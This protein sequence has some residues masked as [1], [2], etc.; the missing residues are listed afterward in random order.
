MIRMA[1][2]VERRFA[3]RVVWVCLLGWPLAAQTSSGQKPAELARGVVIPRVTCVA[4]AQQSYALYLPSN[5]T[6]EH[7][8][9]IIYAFDP[10]AR[11]GLPVELLKEIA[12]RRGY[13]V[14]GS[15]NSR[16]GPLKVSLDAAE[17]V[18]RDTYARLSIDAR[19]VYMTGF[20]GGAR[21]AADI[22]LNCHDCAAGVIAHGAGFE[23]GA[24]KPAEIHFRYFAA[25]GET[26]FNYPELVE[27]EKQLDAWGVSNRVRRYPAGHQWAS[28]E[29]WE[30]AIEWMELQAMKDGR[31]SKNELWISEG[32]ARGLERARK[33][34]QAGDFYAAYEEYR[35]LALD[36][37][38]L[39][40]TAALEQKAGELKKNAAVREG[41][42]REQKEIGQQQQLTSDFLGALGTLQ[43]GA[44]DKTAAIEALS[45]KAADFGS[46]LK[47]AKDL[48]ENRV[49]L[50]A[51]GQV[52]ASAVETGRELFQMKDYPPAEACFKAASQI[53][54][55]AP[56]PYFQLAR[57]YAQ[58][59][60]KKNVA[61][62]LEKA[63]ENGLRVEAL[64]NA[65]ELAAMKDDPEIQRLVEKYSQTR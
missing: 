54:P 28:A 63:F 48:S 61:G 53:S 2:H 12:E 64:E 24:R 43:K 44:L 32:R 5:Y 36:Y 13:I 1:I 3:L 30:E 39:A 10:G 7:A 15:N 16:N 8:W 49:L 50:R 47:R 56:G 34:E 65:P 42:K 35:R 29:I 62:M 20:S 11:G 9:P 41:Q 45:T 52:F 14:A 25:I 23:L 18:W 6:P 19:R 33:L 26:D 51:R 31:L 40:D 38:G 17:A 60:R 55:Q 59:G 57:I 4:D 58:T 21:V 37:R 22:A 27:L 46:R